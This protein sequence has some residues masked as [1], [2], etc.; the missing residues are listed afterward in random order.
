[1][2]IRPKGNRIIKRME[3]KKGRITKKAVIRSNN[4]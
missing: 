2:I 1:M 3:I 4:F